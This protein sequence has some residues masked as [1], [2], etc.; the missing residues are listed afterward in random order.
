MSCAASAQPTWGETLLRS[1]TMGGSGFDDVGAGD[2][3]VEAATIVAEDEAPIGKVKGGAEEEGADDGQEA[4]DD[5][6]EGDECF[7]EEPGVEEA[8][9]GA[10]EAGNADF[11]DD[12]ADR[13]A[14][15]AEQEDLNDE[16]NEPA[17]EGDEASEAQAH[18]VELLGVGLDALHAGPDDFGEFGAE[19]EEAGKA[20]E[21]FE[22][23]VDETR[24]ETRAA[25][26]EI[27]G[28][29]GGGD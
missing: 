3:I 10:V 4:E 12:F 28:S 21:D 15:G 20:A 2:E 23:P 25:F 24:E 8:G 5:A 27:D 22:R 14:A 26:G 7:A 11:G 6:A 29:G 16:E 13:L 18:H 1:A 19:D 9:F 17:G